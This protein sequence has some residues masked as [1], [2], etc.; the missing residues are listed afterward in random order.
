MGTE[1][2]Q[3]TSLSDSSSSAQRVEFLTV[4]RVVDP[5]RHTPT[6]KGE[7]AQRLLAGPQSWRRASLVWHLR[8]FYIPTK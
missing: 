4:L 2:G 1:S 3:M 6:A 5:C 7:H 8:A